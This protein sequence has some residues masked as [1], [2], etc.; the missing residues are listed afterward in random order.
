M[1][2]WTQTVQ[3][4]WRPELAF[5]ERRSAVLRQ[6]EERD[7]LEAFQWA[8]GDV[9]VRTGRF[10]A[11]AVGVN[12]ATCTLQSPDSPMEPVRDALSLFMAELRPEGV[13]LTTAHFRYLLPLDLDPAEA[14][15]LSGVAMASE[16]LPEASPTDWALLLDGRSDRVGADFQVE[17][18]VVGREEVAHRLVGAGRAS[19][20]PSMLEPD[21]RAVPDCALFLT[22]HWTAATSVGGGESGTYEAIWDRLITESSFLS[23][24][25]QKRLEVGYTRRREG[26]A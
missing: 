12:G 3:F 7:L 5:Y 13:V 4:R 17:Y 25:V 21:V 24:K 16:F 26:Q 1:G 6:M 8:V 23:D 2:L 10:E 18:G 14:Q 11:L 15:R 9:T 20:L 22:W 19:D